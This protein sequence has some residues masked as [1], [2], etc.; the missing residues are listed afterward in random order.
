MTGGDRPR[1]AGF[2]V[3]V[4]R[5]GGGVLREA[6]GMGLT[7]FKRFRMEIDLAGRVI[8]PPPPPPGY[9]FLAWDPSLLDAHAV[10]KYRSFRHEVDAA[11]FPCFT[12]LAGCRRLMEEIVHKPGFLADATWLAAYTGGNGELVEFCGTIQGVRDRRG[13]GA[14]QNVGIAPEHRGRSVGTGLI[15]LALDGFRRNGLFRVSLEVTAS[16]AGAIRLYRRLGFRAV[17]TTYRAVEPAPATS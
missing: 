15:Q 16:N 7:Y 4:G 17:K 1:R 6:D 3:A 2:V 12:E 11:L 14:V 5:A 13:V 9:R 8:Q 10:V